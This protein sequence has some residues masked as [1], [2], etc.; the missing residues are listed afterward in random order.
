MFD[1]SIDLI[2]WGHEHDCRIEPE[3]VAGR[4][5]YI[6]QPGSTV[7]TS[8][9]EGEAITKCVFLSCILFPLYNPKIYLITRR[10]HVALLEIQGKAFQINPIALRSVRPFKIDSLV[11]S[12]V[13]EE[14]DININDR[15]AINGMLKRKINEMVADA[16]K[17]Y[18]E[19]MGEDLNLKERILPIIRLRVSLL[20]IDHVSHTDAT[21]VDTTGIPDMTN[22]Q[23]LGLEFQGKIANPRDVL[24]FIRPKA[25]NA[26]NFITEPELEIDKLELGPKEKVDLSLFY[27]P[28]LC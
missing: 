16:V 6:S 5:Y 19:R 21:K 23:R 11:L 22:P 9:A 15:M 8:L 13:V 3:P 14:E 18:K 17:E 24:Q 2:I 27:I 25:K 4:R 28:N 1:N 7:A 10:R 12:Q 20:L 26:K